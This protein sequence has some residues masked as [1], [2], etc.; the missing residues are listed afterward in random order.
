[1]KL[2]ASKAA[3]LIIL[4]FSLVPPLAAQ[5]SSESELR[6]EAIALTKKGEA[7]A[8]KPLL[9][10]LV[11]TY[12]DDFEILDCLA[13]VLLNH[14]ATLNDPG[15]RKKERVRAY[16]IAKKARDVGNSKYG[17]WQ[18]VL[19][20]P[21]DGS[22]LS[23]S[24]NEKAEQLMKAAEADFAKGDLEKAFSGYLSALALEPKLYY[25]A[26]FCG[27]VRYKQGRHEEA[28]P[29]F[30]RATQSDPNIE[31]AHRY[32]ADS[33][34]AAGKLEQAR[35][36][37][38]DAVVADPYKQ[39]TWNALVSWSRRAGVQMRHADVRSPNNFQQQQGGKM[40]INIDPSTLNQKDGREK[41]LVYEIS[42]A[43]WSANDYKLFKEAYPNEKQYRHSLEE[44]ARALRL[45]A[46][47]ISDGLKK[48]EIK[49]L[50][51]SLQPLIR[52]HN[53]G[54]LEAFVLFARADE[55]IAKDYLPY[56]EKN[57][58]KLRQYLEEWVAPL[59]EKR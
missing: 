10:K 9:E 42:R 23:F 54:L 18:V 24:A 44:E 50:H 26:L 6:R 48:G 7:V 33:L 52:L 34:L 28:W 5:R 47:T 14:A 27:D 57:A 56:K 21:E 2:S 3:L 49:D 59:P 40:T 53:A 19:E 58:A 11:Q 45:L 15:E 36:K 32:W 29:W 43:A 22:D 4:C 16:Q 35:L 55:G 8:A 20:I 31:T 41:W 39:W 30:E 46:S 37:A 17:Y 12:P 13:M 51:P 38:I 25:A 1:M